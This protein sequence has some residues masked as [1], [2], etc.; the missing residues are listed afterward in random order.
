M[1]KTC[2]LYPG[3]WGMG[4]LGEVESPSLGASGQRLNNILAEKGPGT[5]LQWADGFRCPSDPWIP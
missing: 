1:D 3:S 4:V 5:P 2:P